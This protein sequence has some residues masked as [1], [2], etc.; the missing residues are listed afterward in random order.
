M[1]ITKGQNKIN[2]RI[3]DHLDA[4][5]AAFENYK[6]DNNRNEYHKTLIKI[7]DE[8]PLDFTLPYS[9]KKNKREKETG[10]LKIIYPKQNEIDMCSTLD[11][12]EVSLLTDNIRHNNR[13]DPK[14]LDVL[15]LHEAWNMVYPVVIGISPIASERD[16]LDFIK[17]RWPVIRKKLNNYGKQLRIRKRP[18]QER[19]DFIWRY[20]YLPPDKMLTLLDDKFSNHDLGV[21]NIRAI[22]KSEKVRRVK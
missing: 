6:R 5:K 17:K 19:N 21:E 8:D 18:Q 20:R 16:V 4:R 13:N 3:K 15:D 10:L 9:I 1:R 2:Q 11:R 12:K 14:I 22:L 7:M